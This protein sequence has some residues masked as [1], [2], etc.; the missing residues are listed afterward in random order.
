MIDTTARLTYDDF[1]AAA[2]AAGRAP[3]LHNSQPWRLRLRDGAMEVLTEPGRRL[4]VADP[5]GWAVRIACGAAVFNARL[6]LVVGGTPVE[7]RLRPEASEPDLLARLCPLPARPATPA[8]IALHGAIRRRHSNRRP[9]ADTPVPVPS[10]ARLIE[11]AREERAWLDLLVGAGPLTAVGEI[12]QAAD[13]VL[14]RSPDYRAE[15][16][17][18]TRPETAATDGVPVA[19]GGPSPEPHDLLSDRDA[20]GYRRAPGRDYE[21]EPLVAILGTTGD[22]P[23]DQLV[24]GQAL[25]HVLL[26]CTDAGLSASM[27]SQPIEVASAREMLRL[28]L[29]RSGSPQMVIRIGYG[30]PSPGTQR[31]P[32]L[33]TIDPSSISGRPSG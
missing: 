30:E 24:A 26:T 6:A 5:S 3:S 31:R 8:E 4:P 29:G 22:T 15:V 2:E 7:V 23:T 13:R 32:V 17:D 33:D 9:F 1:L 11:A 20:G 18:W 14:N 12:A 27:L 10:R 16:A 28:A 25:Q 21:T 19:A